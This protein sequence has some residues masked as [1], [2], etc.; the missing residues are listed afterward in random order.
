MNQM[1][2]DDMIAVLEAA[3]R[4]EEFSYDSVDWSQFFYYAPDSPTGLRWATNEG[5]RGRKDSVAG[6][7]NGGGYWQ[8][9][10]CGRKLACHRIVVRLHGVLIDGQH[11]D[12]F[13]RKTDNNSFE[14]L[15]VKSRHDNMRNRKIGSNNKT[16][17]MG[18]CYAKA[19]NG[20]VATWR[21][22]SGKIKSK[23]FS[24][25]KY[26]DDLAFELAQEF[27]DSQITRLVAEGALYTNH[28]G[29]DHV[30]M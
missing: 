16:G 11:V 28:H 15:Q 18:V 14:N 8:V 30:Q 24:C 20:F 7:I 25:V 3:K 13:D 4:G 21:E 23:Y 2:L 17:K 10:L 1:N 27:R 22:L 6:S 19:T 9:Q 5:Q 29:A 26:G 12:H